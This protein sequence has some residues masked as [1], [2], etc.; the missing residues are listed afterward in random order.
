M[1]IKQIFL[2]F[3]LLLL[4]FTCLNAQKTYTVHFDYDAAGNRTDRFLEVTQLKATDTVPSELPKSI[5]DELLQTLVYPN[6]T[7]G[8]IYIEME[9]NEDNP[10]SYIIV[11]QQGRLCNQGLIV[12]Y[13]TSISIEASVAGVYYLRL[14]NN[15]EQATFKIIKQ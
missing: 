7:Y 12:S 9:P 1:K 8:N 10:V 4:T 5:S 14:Y 15:L 3:G 11:D 13:K 2:I 6:P